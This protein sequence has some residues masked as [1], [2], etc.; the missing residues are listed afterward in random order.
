MNP[1]KCRLV[2]GAIMALA[3]STASWAAEATVTTAVYAKIGSGYSRAKVKNGGFKP[4]YY[5][6]S[7][8]GRIYGTTSDLTVERL[9]Y[10]DV[11][12]IAMPLLAQQNYHYAKSKEQAKL[13]LV[14][15]WGSTLAPNGVHKALNIA[16]AQAERQ[17]FQRTQQ[18]L[19]SL[20]EG[21]GG[22]PQSYPGEDRVA[23]ATAGFGQS[24]QFAPNEE[25]A[26]THAAGSV[27]NSFLR[28][29]VDDHVRDQLNRKNAQ[30]L[31]YID[32]LDESNDIRRYMGGGERY[33]DLI[34]E[35]EESRYY[36]VV[37]AY[38]FPEL[39]KTQKKKLLWQVRVSVRSPG[40][41]FDDSVAAMLK[42]A[43]KYFGQNSGKLVRAEETKGK[44]EMGDVKF[45]G[46]AKDTPPMGK[47]TKVNQPEKK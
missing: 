10:A 17:N 28:S 6:L 16:A 5:A 15:Q 40:N 1:T 8:G 22:P 36:I 33:T 30:V 27:E 19:K 45:L 21:P 24:L 11:A 39:L 44:V 37:S 4:E 2:A 14:L 32:D 41:A 47:T 43:S 18:D 35:V 25:V 3:A 7:N 13:L 9:T 26:L 42:S 38:D 29:Q 34:T 12:A 23:N 31:G 46:E 20:L